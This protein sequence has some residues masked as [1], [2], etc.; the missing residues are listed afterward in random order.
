MLKAQ[1]WRGKWRWMV[2]AVLVLLAALLAVAI[3]WTQNFIRQLPN[4]LPATMA[5]EI[6]SFWRFA[7]ENRLSISPDGQRVATASLGGNTHLWQVNGEQVAKFPGS[8]V[9][10][11]PNGQLLATASSDQTVR[12]WDEREQLITQFKGHDPINGGIRFSQDSQLLFTVLDGIPRAW[13]LKGHP[14]AEFNGREARERDIHLNSGGVKLDMTLSL[15]DAGLT[16]SPDGSHI[17][18]TAY[19]LTRYHA[20]RV[21]DLQGNQIAEL[22]GHQGPINSVCFSPDGT[23]LATASS[24]HTARLWDLQ[25]N[26]LME[27]KGLTESIVRIAFSP[28]GRYLATL[29]GEDLLDEHRLYLWDMQGHLV[30]EVKMGDRS[31]SFPD[32]R[33]FSFSPTSS[34]I[35]ALDHRSFQIFDFQGK[36]LSMTNEPWRYL[37]DRP[38]AISFMS[39]GQQIV[40]ASENGGAVLFDL[41][42]KPLVVFKG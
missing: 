1:K 31:A 32:I 12:I 23:R 38:D 24:D 17:A 16:V 13:N 20:A 7:G 21:W 8:Q 9:T 27:F 29:T 41:Q 5:N 19:S 25:G 34:H 3:A 22:K 35:A 4:Q 40:V 11:S 37:Q 26:L 18:T 6:P 14:L 39:D 30:T 15:N 2:W 28:D 10:F 33:A 36:P 42:G